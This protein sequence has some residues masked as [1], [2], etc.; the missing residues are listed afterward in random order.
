MRQRSLVFQGFLLPFLG[1]SLLPF[2]AVPLSVLTAIARAVG[3]FRMTTLKQNFIHELGHYEKQ[4]SP[5]FQAKSC[6]NKISHNIMFN[7]P[8]AGINFNDGKSRD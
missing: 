4:S 1:V 6:Q 3:L 5:W 7:M 2:R 8:R